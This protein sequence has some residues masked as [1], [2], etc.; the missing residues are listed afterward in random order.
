VFFLYL[1]AG[2]IMLFIFPKGELELL[3]NKHHNSYLDQFFFYITYFGDARILLPILLISFFRKIYHGLL[4]T[5]VFVLSTIVVQSMKRIIFAEYPRPS[6]FFEKH[7]D[8]HFIEGL[9]LHTYYSFPSG[10][11]S[12]AF[13]VFFTLG[14]LV[15]EKV[16]AVLFF[17][18]A[19]L[20][21]FSRVY[22][23]QHF[24]IDT[25]FGALLGVLTS[26]IVYYFIDRKSTLPQKE[27]LNKPLFRIFA[28]K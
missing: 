20:V 23:M 25:Y 5:L 6:K 19:L 18:I 11:S 3:V 16:L 8:L 24:F 15:R 4:V 1:G 9:E 13:A 28:R 14:L 17:I 21:A 27:S 26:I 10:H 22:L 7:I 12:G 2:V